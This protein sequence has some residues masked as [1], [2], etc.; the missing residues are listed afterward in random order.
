MKLGKL[1]LGKHLERLGYGSVPMKF[2]PYWAGGGGIFAPGF[3]MFKM[4]P[5]LT[6]D[7]HLKYLSKLIIFGF[8]CFT[9]VVDA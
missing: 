7:K 4:K 6:T 5:H 8:S 3:L 1:F 9:I 2:N